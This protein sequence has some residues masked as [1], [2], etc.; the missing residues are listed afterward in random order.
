MYRLAVVLAL[1]L[2][3]PKAWAVTGATVPWTTYEAESMANSGVAMG[4]QYVPNV[5]ESES[6]GRRCVKLDAT[7][8]YVQFTALAAANSIVVRYS[9]PDSGDGVGTDSTISLYRNGSFVGKLPVTSKYSWRYGTY[10]FS[11]TPTDGLPRNFYDEVRTN[12][13]A[14][15]LG[16]VIRLQKDGDDSASYYVIDLVDLENSPAAISQPGGFVSIKSAPYN[17]VGNGVA[18]DTAALQNCINAN[19]NVWIPAGTYKLTGSI[20]LPSNK[21]VRGAGMWHTTLL[22]DPSLY[23]TSSERITMN[24]NG[25]NIQLADFAII[26]KLNY[27]NDSEPNDG[28][29][30]AYGT[31]STISRIWV[32]HT[33]T[34]GWIV[35]S[36]G[37]VVD[38]CRFRNTLADGIAMVVGMRG[39]TV[40]NCTA[41]GTGDDCFAI[42]PAVYM[43]QTYTPGLNVITRCTGQVPFLANGGS[44]YGG[45][46]NRIE[47]CLFQD[48][49]YGCGVLLSTTFSVG[50]NNFS[51]TTVVQRSDLIRCGGNDQG[52]GW[53]GSMQFCL[54]NANNNNISGVNVN[55]LFIT[56]SVSDGISIIGKSGTTG[57]L[58]SALLDS[59]TIPN[60]GIGTSGRHG[61]W[62]RSDARGSMTVSNSAIVEHLDASANFSFTFVTSTVPVTVQTSPAG[63]SFTVDGTPYSSA[64][65][66]NWA[67]GSAHTIATTSP[68]SGGAGVQYV[69]SDWSDG[70]AISHGVSPTSGTTY[71]ANFATQYFLT[72][73]AS[74]GGTVSPVSGWTNS[75]ASVGLSATASN[76]YTFAGWTGSGS[77]S[78]TGTNNPAT[79]TMNGPITQ[80][81]T[82]VPNVSVAVQ[83][84]PSGR[85]FTVDGTNYT[86]TQM[87]SW[88][89]G[90]SHT[91]ET[92]SPQSGGA[93]V[94]Y[95]WNNWSDGGAISHSVSPTSNV[96]YTANFATQYFLT[97]NAGMGGTVSPASH[98]TNS[99]ATVSIS[100]TAS[101]GYSF[102]GWTGS[103]SGA[104]SGSANPT[105]ITMNGP[106]TQMGSFE[107]IPTRILSLSGDLNFGEVT[108]GSSSNQTFVISNAGNATLT[109]SNIIYPVGF[110]GTW[111][112]AIPANESTNVGATFMPLA[113]TGYGGNLVVT[114]DATDGTN[115]LALSGTGVIQ[116]NEVPPQ[117]IVSVTVND[118]SVVVTYTTTPGV[119]YH[120]ESTT[121]LPPV[122]WTTVLGSTTNAT[123]SVVTFIDVG[124]PGVERYYR[125]VSP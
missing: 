80:T 72:V 121:N 125:V 49:T 21:N 85:A 74:A 95:V 124:P 9:V 25:S 89:P 109:V 63:R 83:A 103:G 53:R 45:Q 104:Y 40:T 77:G 116:T 111:S 4:P 17:A 86:T 20:T 28:L 52:Y 56:N 100:A 119:D 8:E 29:G 64:Q 2:F 31:G 50:G 10:P 11:N 84:S 1:M 34:G 14:I 7:G 107:L 62:A 66:F 41:R 76:G 37:L 115:T 48:I 12:G 19:A 55:N 32:E 3:L 112:G 110:I 101:N 94:Q 87:F 71:T 106:I 36:Q 57:T 47:D 6:S 61:L 105:V 102:T 42:W 39:S 122:A 114:S 54:D 75:G 93:G 69:W 51:G 23:G 117:T 67:A 13:V 70:G 92:I 73:N 99:G 30:G 98:W 60:Y 59:V 97:M 27:R 120:V 96:T 113:A 35:N 78:Y 65:V 22:G 24:G 81:A 33:K 16:D 44:I 58:S 90:S 18:D 46:S 43:G 123:A 68:Q 82:F 38:S 118:E 108:V 91:I 88:V 26:G 79:I 15:S 5:V